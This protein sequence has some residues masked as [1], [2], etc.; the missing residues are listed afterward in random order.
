MG[1]KNV[2]Q[3]IAEKMPAMSKSQEKLAAYIIN[4][5]NTVPF[6]T[7]ATLAK[8]TGVSE[9]S[10]VRFAV[11]LGFSGY[12]ELQN[13]MQNSV[14]MQLTTRD[15][16]KMSSQVYDDSNQDIY[17]IFKDDIANIKSTMENLDSKAFLDAANL[18]IN[19][20]EVY[21]S[22]NRS[23]TSLGLFLQYYLD[24]I[25]GNAQLLGPV[26]NKPE[27]LYRLNEKDVVVGI[28]FSRYSTST[29]NMIAFA[30]ERGATTIVITDNFLSPLVPHA[31]VVLTA[32][33]QL[34]TFFDSFV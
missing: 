1:Q 18:L 23:A 25:I 32:S 10:V 3:L 15:R 11:F 5:P 12:R 27:Q 21:I 4:N 2:Y 22:A 29:V 30:K 9:A 26:E 19:G 8:L 33:S 7:V 28:S 34:P 17:D 13:Q 6:Y 31:D 16:L 20:K 24:I 14:Q